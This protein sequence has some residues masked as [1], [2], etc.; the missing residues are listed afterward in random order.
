[1]AITGEW[2]GCCYYLFSSASTRA[3]HCA[4]RQ[5]AMGGQY[6]NPSALL[7]DQ[8]L[9]QP[10]LPHVQT[11]THLCEAS[12]I[13]YSSR[14]Q[15]HHPSPSERHT[16]AE[17]NNYSHVILPVLGRPTLTPLNPP[18]VTT[19][20]T[21]NTSQHFRLRRTQPPAFIQSGPIEMLNGGWTDMTLEF[22]NCCFTQSCCS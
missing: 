17:V 5:L 1:M 7:S 4:E 6:K 22:T 18:D 11:H 9:S 3:G 16:T 21:P 2:W 13:L 10:L 14:N 20:T 19:H 15:H 8:P 12:P